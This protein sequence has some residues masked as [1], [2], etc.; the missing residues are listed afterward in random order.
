MTFIARLLWITVSAAIAIALGAYSAEHVTRTFDGFAPLTTG[1]WHAYPGIAT[2][3]ADPYARAHMSRTGRLP[4][5]DT[6][7]IV[8]S[9]Q[10]DD[11]GAPLVSTCNYALVG[12]VPPNRLWTFTVTPVTSGS[13]VMIAP[14][15]TSRSHIR[16]AND[17]VILNAGPTPSGGNWFRFASDGDVATPLSMVLS[18]YDSPVATA[19]A[20]SELK[21]PSIT[22][23]DCLDG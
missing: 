16:S 10:T 11:T 4:V 12:E 7:G 6:E 8:F 19:S 17:Q 15:I 13:N 22:R 21:M 1:A 5:A 18:L 20:F 2:D 23:K 14:P 9:A 3:S